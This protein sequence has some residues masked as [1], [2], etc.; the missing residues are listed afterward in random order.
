MLYIIEHFSLYSVSL[1][2]R[3]P[4]EEANQMFGPKVYRL[5]YDM[6]P[7]SAGWWDPISIQNRSS[8]SSEL[9]DDPKA[10][11]QSLCTHLSP[12]FQGDCFS[13]GRSSPE[14][15]FQTFRI[16]YPGVW[17]DRQERTCAA[18]GS[19]RQ[20]D[21]R[22]CL[23]IKRWNRNPVMWKLCHWPS[24]CFC[25]LV[26]STSTSTLL[27]PVLVVLMYSAKIAVHMSASEEPRKNLWSR[28]LVTSSHETECGC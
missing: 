16:L 13:R 18:P 1:G 7:G 11:V 25:G 26:S 15:L 9:P 17:A 23:V 19:D 8:F 14:H 21:Q 12:T 22:N 28:D 3:K 4:S 20:T 6:G 27:L 2:R 24:E 5:P 10:A